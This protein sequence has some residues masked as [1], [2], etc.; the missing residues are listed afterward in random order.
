MTSVG[1]IL[2]SQG[3]TIRLTNRLLRLAGED[4][5]FSVCSD[6]DTGSRLLAEQEN[7]RYS[8]FPYE[9]PEIFS[10]SCLKFFQGG[11]SKVIFLFFTRRVD[12]ILFNNIPVYN[13]HE[14]LLPKHSGLGGLRKTFESD[15]P[16][17]GLTFHKVSENL[18]AG[19]VLMQIKARRFEDDTYEKLAEILFC[20]KVILLSSL[21]RKSIFTEIEAISSSR[22]RTLRENLIYFYDLLSSH[23]KER[24]DRKCDVLLLNEPLCSLGD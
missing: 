18:D 9:T 1:T 24:P 17:F 2:S 14:S 8:L 20:M 19:R 6:R 13:F 21:I 12:E 16:E 22:S 11:K 3:G 10:R 23:H 7:M 5:L 4:V 15:D